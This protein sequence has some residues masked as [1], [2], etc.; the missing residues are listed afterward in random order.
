MRRIIA[1]LPTLLVATS[2]FSQLIFDVGVSPS[3]HRVDPG[4]EVRFETRINWVGPPPAELRVR[5]A[6]D[7]GATIERIEGGSPWTCTIA[8]NTAECVLR[9]GLE[10]SSR[11]HVI[12][13][14]GSENG[15]HATFTMTSNGTFASAALQNYHAFFVRNTA[16]SG[17]GSLRAAIEEANA[18]AKPSKIVFN[19]PTPVPAEGWFTIIPESPLPPITTSSMFVDGKSQTRFTG[20]TNPRGPEIAI[21]G[22]LA[23]RGLE[24]HSPCENKVEGLV[25]GNFDRNQGLWFTSTGECASGP[26]TIN[27]ERWV[28]DNYIG[29]DPTG[30]VAWPNLRGLR[31]DFTHGVVRNNVISGN[32]YS[33]M[34][35]WQT[36]ARIQSLVVENNRFGTAADGV[37]PLPNGAAGMML[38]PRVT[39]DVRGNVI[40]YHPGM[41]I[42]LHPSPQTWADIRRN[43][44]IDNGGIGID[45]GI[46]GVSPLRLDDAK[47]A[48]NAPTLLSGR[49]DAASNR[50]YFTAVLQNERILGASAGRISVDFYANRAPNGDGEQWIGVGN[51]V[52]FDEIRFEGWIA[53]DHRGKW[54]NAT[55]TRTPVFFA[56]PPRLEAFTRNEPR[57]EVVPDVPALDEGSTSELSNA[58]RIE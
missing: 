6:V 54:I 10:G 46:D 14:T 21:D 33:G 7:A 44:M 20:D 52:S 31:A 32:T 57:T 3:V 47:G 13:R 23:H 49:F 2:A 4:S 11:I 15:A 24:I 18:L 43:S 42:A 36:A 51:E 35:C 30:T 27:S 5:Y 29:T 9:P 40:S 56:R 19:L 25:L 53:G 37:T 12:A 45:W 38:G 28:A 34:W 41:G 48:P 26:F 39:A 8:G 50:T 58:I 55:A 16:D 17:P 22:H 1:L